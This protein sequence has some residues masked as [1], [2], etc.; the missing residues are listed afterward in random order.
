ME[1]NS[2]LERYP[3]YWRGRLRRGVGLGIGDQY[4][5]WLRVR[6]IR[7]HGTSGNPRG[8]TIP[9]IY[10]LLS[11]PE[12][13]FFH[14]LDRQADVVDIREQFPIL[15]LS[16]TLT[17]CGELGQRHAR[18]GSFP[19][20]F[21]LDF[22]VTRETPTG[23]IYQARDIKTAENAAEQRVKARTAVSYEW[24]KRNGLDWKFVDTSDFSN[25]VLATLTFMRGWSRHLFV[26]DNAEIEQFILV[27]QA[28]YGRNRPL[29]E[30][31]T[32]C[33]QHLKRSY[34]DCLN[35]FRFCAWADHIEVDVRR[36]LALNLPVILREAAK[37]DN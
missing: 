13:I 24:C 31:I 34:D 28:N 4:Q 6:D 8:I 30:I 3:K 20:P 29:R 21:T 1:W 33:S 37:N 9:R 22:V 18:I 7:S 2:E 19:E 35:S 16:A 11:T 23:L 10:H 32:A 26:P 14:L 5:P 15:D 17:I 36:K 25:D 27:F 12:R